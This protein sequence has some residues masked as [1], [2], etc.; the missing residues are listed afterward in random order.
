MAAR[1]K[2][3][4]KWIKF[5]FF[6]LPKRL[7]DI[8]S[9]FK[10]VIVEAHEHNTLAI[11]AAEKL[12][13]VQRSPGLLQHQIQ[14]QIAK[15]RKLRI[16]HGLRASN[17]LKEEMFTVN[18]NFERI[19]QELLVINILLKDKAAKDKANE[20]TLSI[21]MTKYEEIPN[22]CSIMRTELS[23]FFVYKDRYEKIEGLHNK[24]EVDYASYIKKFKS[25]YSAFKK[26]DDAIRRLAH[27]EERITLIE[28]SN[29]EQ[30]K[31]GSGQ[32][33]SG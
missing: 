22:L 28:L 33:V 5:R 15:E 20:K 26:N 3:F 11:E 9:Q 27:L 18:N 2:S 32:A 23:E 24:M 13:E 21:L 31:H 25:E 12:S 16:A 4:F 10:T 8:E 6:D 30:R 19:R 1:F 17:K 7:N 29:K 14:Y